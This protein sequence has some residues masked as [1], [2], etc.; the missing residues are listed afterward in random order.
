ML[1]VLLGDYDYH[2]HFCSRASTT[3]SLATGIRSTIDLLVEQAVR[4]LF[5][6][7]VAPQR[8]CMQ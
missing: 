8:E 6:R 2:V 4:S 5:S 3:M 7:S 1:H